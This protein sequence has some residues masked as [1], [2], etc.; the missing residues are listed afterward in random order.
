MTIGILVSFGL[1][2]LIEYTGITGH[3]HATIDGH[4]K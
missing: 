3:S 2:G 4:D 1:F